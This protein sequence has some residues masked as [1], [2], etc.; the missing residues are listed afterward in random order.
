MKTTV[1][2]SRS[3]AK[4]FDAVEDV[5]SWFGPKWPEVSDMMKSITDPQTFAFYANFGGVEG[6]PVEAWYDL[7]HGQGAYA[8]AVGRTA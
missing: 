5:K 3:P 2:Y 8:K 4:A 7:Y 6:Y 1:D